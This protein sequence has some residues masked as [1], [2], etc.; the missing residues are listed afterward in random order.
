MAVL[1]Q[2]R[3]DEHAVNSA[4]QAVAASQPPPIARMRRSL[5]RGPA[6][7]SDSLDAIRRC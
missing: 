2:G 1:S 4:A 6:G 7:F 5:A 3:T